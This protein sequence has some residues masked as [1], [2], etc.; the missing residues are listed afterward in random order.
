[1]EYAAAFLAVTKESIRVSTSAN[2]PDAFSRA[3]VTAV[4]G[5]P[6]PTHLQLPGHEGEVLEDEEVGGI[7]PLDGR[8]ASVP[9]YRPA[10]EPAAVRTA[11][12]ALAR[13]ARP[14]IVAGGGV[15]WSGAE[16]GRVPVNVAT[17]T[18]TRGV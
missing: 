7:P 5:H 13:A 3:V 2:L 10:A 9:L 6:G 14:V 8:Y 11:A 16:A 17:L 18:V 15:R 4:S 12:Q 1:M